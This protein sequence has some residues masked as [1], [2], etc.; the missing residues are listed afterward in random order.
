L[1]KYYFYFE[2]ANYFTKID[3]E[4]ILVTYTP[5]GKPDL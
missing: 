1:D 3:L 2:E 5:C 4:W